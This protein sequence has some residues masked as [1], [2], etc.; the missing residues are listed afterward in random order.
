MK[1]QL[2]NVI[3]RAETLAQDRWLVPLNLLSLSTYLE[4]AGY[5]AEILDGTH[6]SHEDMLGKID[7]EIVGINFNIF[8]VKEM[9]KV[10]GK[11]K[12]NGA[13]VVL[14]GHAA[15]HLSRQLL[16]KNKNIDLVVRYDGEEAL[17]QIAERV[18]TKRRDFSRIP[19]V[20]Y[21]SKDQIV[22]EP[23]QLLDLTS[24]P[25]PN[26][27]S[28]GINLEDYISNFS[29][30][31][32]IGEFAKG[33]RP[34]NVQ[35]IRGC[36]HACSFCGRIYKGGRMRHP[37]QVYEEDKMLV[38]TSG[39]NY[40][41]ETADSFFMNKPW[42][43]EVVEVYRKRGRLPVNYWA[44]CHIQDIDWET[45]EAMKFFNV[46][47]V[48]V[49]IESGNEEVRRENG[50]CFSDDEIFRATSLLG[51]AG[52]KLQDNYLLGLI[53]ESQETIQDTYR[54]AKKVAETC[55]VASI[56]GF[57]LILPTPG[58][59]IWAKMM[60]IPEFRAKYREDYKFDI[61]ELRRDYLTHFCNL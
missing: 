38:E 36:N 23:V 18:S 31:P 48:N 2:V 4:Q 22:E 33:R 26:R 16:T 25:I 56:R 35:S 59:P 14:G 57:H 46:D 61:E 51:Q 55:Q 15:T 40:I 50:K 24:L 6:I 1:V 10:A 27:R 5:E 32:L 17:R 30:I 3:N 20:S 54:L 53:G 29:K 7:G 28:R 47:M 12:G 42:L 13:L 49:G 19:N 8:S 11:A 44:L 60:Q 37:E 45:I 58:S 43:K 21:R 34:S 41:Y 39:V 9:E 52:I